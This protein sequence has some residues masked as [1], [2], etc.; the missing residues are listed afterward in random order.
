MLSKVSDISKAMIIMEL[1]AGA[2]KD[3]KSV[4]LSN[5]EYILENAHAARA[6]GRTLNHFFL[7][8][9]F[10]QCYQLI[11]LL[12]KFPQTLSVYMVSQET[13]QL[14]YELKIVFDH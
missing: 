13:R 11:S 4:A 12:Q 1:P 3:K 6:P 8:L 9:L 14:R 2:N 5:L 10:F 7:I